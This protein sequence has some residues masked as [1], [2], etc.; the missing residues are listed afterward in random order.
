MSELDDPN[1]YSEYPKGGPS[2][3][4][5]T[6]DIRETQAMATPDPN[7][8]F[9]M[10]VALKSCEQTAAQLERLFV[11]LEPVMQKNGMMESLYGDETAKDVDPSSKVSRIFKQ[12]AQQQRRIQDRIETALDLLDV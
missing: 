4:S 7:I 11:R 9:Q 3:Q 6:S 12:I 5:Y 1:M 2:R 8:I 10:E